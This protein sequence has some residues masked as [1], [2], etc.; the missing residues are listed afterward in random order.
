VLE[1][2]TTIIITFFSLTF[3]W[4]TIA[5]ITDGKKNI[6]FLSIMGT[7]S[8]IGFICGI[9]MAQKYIYGGM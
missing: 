1:T 9:L 6:N 7:I 5:M 8:I 2:T 4:G 3:L